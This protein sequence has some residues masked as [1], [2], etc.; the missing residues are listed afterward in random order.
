M[1]WCGICL[2]C[3]QVQAVLKR[4]EEEDEQM[5]QLVQTLQTALEKEKIRVKTL[6]EQVSNF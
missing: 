3:F 2:T 5:R 6:T 1:D 4:K